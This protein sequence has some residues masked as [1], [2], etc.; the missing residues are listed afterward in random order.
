MKRQC[1]REWHRQAL[2]ALAKTSYLNLKGSNL[3]LVDIRR[4]SRQC[5]SVVSVEIDWTYSGFGT[6]VLN[7]CLRHWLHLRE[8]TIVNI[9]FHEPANLL[10]AIISGGSQLRRLFLTGY[11]FHLF[12]WPKHLDRL[13]LS[14][15]ESLSLDIGPKNGPG[16][17]SN[18]DR[19]TTVFWPSEAEPF[20]LARNLVSSSVNSLQCVALTDCPL[21]LIQT[22][23]LEL[24]YLHTF[25]YDSRCP[26]I[27][28]PYS[29]CRI[30][31][32]FVEALTSALVSRSSKRKGGRFGQL[33]ELRLKHTSFGKSALVNSTYLLNLSQ[34]LDGIEVLEMTYIDCGGGGGRFSDISD[35]ELMQQFANKLRF[36]THLMLNGFTNL[37]DGFIHECGLLAGGVL[38]HLSLNGSKIT[39]GGLSAVADAVVRQDRVPLSRSCRWAAVKAY[40]AALR[41]VLSLLSLH[42]IFARLFSM[43]PVSPMTRCSISLVLWE[44]L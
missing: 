18:I 36:T 34:Q 31:N 37:S 4:L 10:E 14:N 32:I 2:S 13:S 42:P 44:G 21:P 41:T 11:C 8:L 20:L 9:D 16:G 3:N 24:P 28:G 19:Q 5:P 22:V 43:T 35:V 6:V 7:H 40:V 33:R 39:D 23:L 38:T 30:S 25:H 29:M 27:I 26:Y 17:K 12:N 15:L 1:L